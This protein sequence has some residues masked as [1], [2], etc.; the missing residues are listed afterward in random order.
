MKS[1]L[2]VNLMQ[3][4]DSDGCF[5]SRATGPGWTQLDRNGFTTAMVLRALRDLPTTG[6]IERLRSAS[7][8]FIGRCRSPDMPSAFGFWPANGRPNWAP[9]LSPDCDDT[10]V[11]IIELIRYG[12]LTRK[13]GLRTVC[14][15]LIPHRVC[16]GA[17][18]QKPSLVTPGAFPTWLDRSGKPNVVDCCVNANVAALMALVGATHLPGFDEAVST[19]VNG[20]EWAGENPVRQQALTP[21]Y[22]SIHSLH[23]AVAHAV[24]CGAISLRSAYDR[25]LKLVGYRSPKAPSRFCCSA[26]GGVE[27]HCDALELVDALP[28]Q[29]PLRANNRTLA[30]TDSEQQENVPVR[31][32]VRS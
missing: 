25:L 26:Y 10:A 6:D 18:K 3:M 14:L 16:S 22:P 17:E 8:D 31:F 29:S 23:E 7:L 21:F 12:R 20:I 30:F 13:D 19:I 9:H 4:Q 27:W 2:V 5:V 24:A 28:P 15:V 11:M 1:N 32:F